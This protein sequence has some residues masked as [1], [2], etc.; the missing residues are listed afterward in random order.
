MIKCNL[1]TGIAEQ[2][3]GVR[4]KRHLRL[5]RLGNIAAPF[6]TDGHAGSCLDLHIRI[7]I[8]FPTG[9]THRALA[10]HGGDER[11]DV[12]RFLL[13]VAL[14]AYAYNTMLA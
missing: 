1:L 5:S 3:Y 10:R 13:N 6:G 8:Q 12:P 14:N 9:V 11:R 2:P 7:D 4:N